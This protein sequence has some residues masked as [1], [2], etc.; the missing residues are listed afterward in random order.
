[1]QKND[2]VF[3]CSVRLSV[4]QVEKGVIVA[5]NRVSTPEPSPAENVLECVTWIQKMAPSPSRVSTK[6]LSDEA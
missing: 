6:L 1:M 4:S 2:A 3:I 5:S